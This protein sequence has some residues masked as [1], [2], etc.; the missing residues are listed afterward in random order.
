MQPYPN[1]PEENNR[2]ADDVKEVLE[3]ITAWRNT[4][5][6][7]LCIKLARD[8]E[9]EIKQEKKSFLKRKQPEM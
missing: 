4:Y 9:N 6:A 7:D 8:V 1:I 2:S 3:F 5:T